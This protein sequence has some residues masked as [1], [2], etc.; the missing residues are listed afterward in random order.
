MSRAQHPV[1]SQEAGRGSPA[2]LPADL[3]CTPA[4]G[5]TE[6]LA[7]LSCRLRRQ[8]GPGGQMLDT[9]SRAVSPT[10]SKLRDGGNN[11]TLAHACPGGCSS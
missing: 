3:R 11:N 1:P 10:Q 4:L 5:T 7:V 9:D 8:Q 2:Q 6:L